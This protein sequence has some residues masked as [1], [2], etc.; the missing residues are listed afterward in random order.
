MGSAGEAPA[1]RIE[2]AGDAIM[3]SREDGATAIFNVDRA[4]AYARAFSLQKGVY[5][6]TA[7]A[8]LRFITCDGYGPAIGQSDDS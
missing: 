1:E 6:N 8:E 7:G 3:A 5:G 4:E 2:C